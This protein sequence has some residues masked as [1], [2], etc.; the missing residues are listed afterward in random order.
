MAEISAIKLSIITINLNNSKGL[1]KSIESVVNQSSKDFEYIV[2]DGGST[3]ESAETIK[4]HANQITYWI[5]EP[6][7]GVYNAMNK[8]IAK[9]KGEYCYFLNSGDVLVDNSILEKI[10]TEKLSADIIAFDAMV[11]EGQKN[12]LVKA[13]KEISFYTFYTHTIL[14]QATFI[15]RSLFEKYGWYNEQL[16]IVADWEFFIKALF[17]HYSTYQY[18]PLTLSVFDTTGISSQLENYNISVKERNTVLKNYFP[19]FIPD[20]NLIAEKSIYTFLTN[21]RE[22]KLLRLFFIFRIKVINK[23][24]KIFNGK[25]N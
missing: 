1:L 11:N 23:L 12:T 14:H 25:N 15:K 5:S 2:I 4:T 9:A 20:Y 22:I 19:H 3:D 7:K 10:F 17:L 24:I 16:K 21:S 8:G 18:I 13:P 6:D